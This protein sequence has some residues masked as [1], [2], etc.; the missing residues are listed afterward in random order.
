MANPFISFT[1]SVTQQ[2]AAT[3]VAVNKPAG[4]TGVGGVVV[5]VFTAFWTVAGNVPDA[6]MTLPSGWVQVAYLATAT[7]TVKLAYKVSVVGGEPNS[8]TFT[9]AT[10]ANQTCGVDRWAN[11]DITQLNDAYVPVTIGSGNG[12]T[13]TALDVVPESDNAA[14]LACFTNDLVTNA[15]T[16]PA[17]FS[18]AHA[19]TTLVRNTVAYEL[20][21][22][23]GHSGD[24]TATIP[25]AANWIAV[26]WAMRPLDLGTPITVTPG[27]VTMT[28]K[29]EITCDI[30]NN[31]LN[32][33][34]LSSYPATAVA[35]MQGLYARLTAFLGGFGFND[36]MYLWDGTGAV[37][38]VGEVRGGV[39]VFDIGGAQRYLDIASALGIPV[40]FIVWRLPWQFTY[41]PY[42]GINSV[43]ADYYGSEERRIRADK[44]TDF[45]T[46]LRR[47]A[48]W[49]IARFVRRFKTGSEWKGWHLDT[50]HTPAKGQTWDWRPAY[51]FYTWCQDAIWLGADDAGV[52]RTLI[53]IGTPYFAVGNDGAANVNS[54]TF[55]SAVTETT[56]VQTIRY[57]DDAVPPQWNLNNPA[58]SYPQKMG[59]RGSV[60]VMK[61]CINNNRPVD[62]F[63][64]D[65]GMGYLDHVIKNADDFYNAEWI[66]RNLVRW[67]KRMLHDVGDGRFANV[68]IDIAEF[69]MKASSTIAQTN[70]TL[71]ADT[72][73]LGL[74][75][76]IV[77]G[78]Y[79]P[80]NQW[81]PFFA[82]L[83][84]IGLGVCVEEGVRTPSWWSYDDDGNGRSYPAV[85]GGG[86]SDHQAWYGEHVAHKGGAAEG[87]TDVAEGAITVVGQTIKAI[88][89]NFSSGTQIRSVTVSDPTKV[90]ALSN[91]SICMV[92]NK[93]AGRKKVVVGAA[94]VVLEPFDTQFPVFALSFS[95]TVAATFTPLTL[96]AT[97]TR[98]LPT[99]SGAAAITLPSLT[100]SAT[101]NRTQ[102][103]YS[104]VMALTLPSLTQSA[105]GAFDVPTYTGSADIIL[106]TLEVYSENSFAP[107]TYDG[108]IGL[109]LPSLTLDA[110]GNYN[111]VAYTGSAT[112]PLSPL[113]LD[114]TGDYIGPSYEAVADS[115]LPSLTLDATG[116]YIPPIIS[117]SADL[118]L[119]II[120]MAAAGREN[121]P[122]EPLFVEANIETIFVREAEAPTVFVVEADAETYFTR[123]AIS[124]L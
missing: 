57:K 55:D 96:A 116:D 23:A 79:L 109:T 2:S 26:L 103:V 7:L 117:G 13:L 75:G 61:L 72:P 81:R 93:T 98:T 58:M 71:A 62:F 92:A 31:T 97:G 88:N 11:V 89:Q 94:T 37:P 8:Y 73:G 86:P 74:A 27:S 43:Q 82:A 28:S 111:I 4:T 120:I 102:P 67:A 36:P 122:N 100:A 24:L 12:T 5:D 108:S 17:G 85:T 52:S 70:N 10:A 77:P 87:D 14:L 46:Y 50:M 69:Y 60:E 84:A 49:L 63:S 30:T 78:P 40:D 113:T 123:S 95:G 68:N 48:A 121:Y 15:I 21:P 112:M 41:S 34:T 80:A 56:P 45:Q 38:T 124:K 114:A 101:G 105:S 6:N 119:S 53:E 35:S 76:D 18:T 1:H 83:K 3:T 107:P 51:D 90:Y 47:Y 110:T 29:L 104:G 22:A 25:T 118:V 20:Q 32:F 59:A 66:V 65:W 33:P 99:F 39:K 9:L 115:T 16:I 19:H 64:Y 54:I 91:L 106:F 44:V 42:T